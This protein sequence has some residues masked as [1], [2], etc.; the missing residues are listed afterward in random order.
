MTDIRDTN[1]NES[2]EC[3]VGEVEDG[4]IEWQSEEELRFNL[5]WSMDATSIESIVVLNENNAPC[6]TFDESDIEEEGLLKT[7]HWAVE[8]QE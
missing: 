6:H 7:E 3:K 2:Y 1:P 5:I 8:I 4:E